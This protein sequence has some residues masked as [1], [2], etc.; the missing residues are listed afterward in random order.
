MQ[1]SAPTA[2][3]T[4]NILIYDLTILNNLQFDDLQFTIYLQFYNLAIYKAV[5]NSSF[6]ILHLQRAAERS[7]FDFSLF[8]FHFAE[9]D[10]V[11]LGERLIAHEFPIIIYDKFVSNSW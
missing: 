1:T 4:K 2:K 6:L 5:A 7:N 9:G 3:R 10:G 8:T 11:R